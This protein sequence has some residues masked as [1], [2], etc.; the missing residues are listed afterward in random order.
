MP[1]GRMTHS[2][3]LDLVVS[4]LDSHARSA[5]QGAHSKNILSTQNLNLYG[6]VR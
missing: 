6:N 5:S 1:G 4:A 2:L 3:R